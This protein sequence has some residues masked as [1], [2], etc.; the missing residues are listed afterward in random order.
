MLFLSKIDIVRNSPHFQVMLNVTGATSRKGMCTESSTRC[1][2][3]PCCLASHGLL[4]SRSCNC[5][6]KC[7]SLAKSTLSKRVHIFRLCWTSLERR[8]ARIIHRMSNWSMLP[9]KSWAYTFS[10]GSQVPSQSCHRK[11][12]CYSLAKLTLSQV[13]HI[14]RSCWTSLEQCHAGPSAQDHPQSSAPCCLAS[15]G[16]VP[17]RTCHRLYKCN[18]LAKSTLSKLVHNFKSCWRGNTWRVLA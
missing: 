3:A 17:S 15:H 5:K 6:Y 18:S 1:L 10:I 11:Y 4:P 16:L 13:V 14:F 9:G 2:L 8:H 7:Y 12:K